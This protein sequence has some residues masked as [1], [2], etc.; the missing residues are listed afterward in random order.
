MDE[1]HLSDP[2]HPE[3]PTQLTPPVPDDWTLC[4]LC[5]NKASEPLQCPGK[6]KRSA[7]GSGHSTL[8]KNSERFKELRSIPLKLNVSKLDDGEG[9]KKCLKSN[10][11]SWHKS[12]YLKFNTTMVKR[13]EKKVSSLIPI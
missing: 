6:S 2:A 4:I 11:A 5:Q 13:A 10:E 7:C 9:I 12:C 1:C 8:F 3:T